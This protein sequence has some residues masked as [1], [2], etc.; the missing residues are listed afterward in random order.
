VASVG[1]LT[2]HIRAVLDQ[3]AAVRSRLLGST[4]QLAEP[5]RAYHSLGEG[6]S[7]PDL[8]NA[9]SYLE[10]ADDKCRTALALVSQAMDR[11]TAYLLS[12][13][14]IQNQYGD[15]YPIE[16]TPYVDSLPPRVGN[17]TNGEMTGYVVIDGREYGLI[18]ATRRDPWTSSVQE[19]L[20][21][22]GFGTRYDWLSN[23][24]EMKVV[25][26][27]IQSG[28]RIATVTINNAPCGSQSGD[29]RGCHQLL[30]GFLPRGSSLTVLGTDVNG[31]PFQHTYQGKADL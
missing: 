27:M 7:Q 1:E 16:A 15:R 2:A 13:G 20:D 28:K 6:S 3:L 26:A 14:G 25:V 31:Q 10:Y 23:H 9:A 29:F 11:L 4:E 5:G 21:R 19:R 22:L 30:A 8:G 24:V 18:T 17:K 12:I